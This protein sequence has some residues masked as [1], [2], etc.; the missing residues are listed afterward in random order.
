MTSSALILVSFSPHLTLFI[1][2]DP[3]SGMLIW[4]LATAGALGLFFYLGSI[5]RKI[6]ARIG[7]REAEGSDEPPISGD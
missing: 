2:A 3:G 4:Q 5:V 7:F 6:R 1:Y